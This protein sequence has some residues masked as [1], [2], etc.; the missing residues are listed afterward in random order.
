MKLM[1]GKELQRAFRRESLGAHG[2][3]QL[4]RAFIRAFNAMGPD[5]L[6]K[7]YHG[8]RYQVTFKE[9]RGVGRPTPRC[10]LCDVMIIHY[11]ADNPSAAR[12]TF[13]QAK[14]T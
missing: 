7:E 1:T 5:A 14:V 11:P 10:E 13:N 9:G 2:E 12:I 3:I 6:A 4:F 8:S